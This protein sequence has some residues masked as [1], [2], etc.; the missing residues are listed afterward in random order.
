MYSGGLQ[1]RPSSSDMAPASSVLFTH[2]RDG[3]EPSLMACFSWSC[4]KKRHF[5][6]LS[7][8]A[9]VVY[10]GF[11]TPEEEAKPGIMATRLDNTA[12][13][14]SVFQVLCV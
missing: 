8:H 1:G 13:S 7:L 3:G 5:H 12:G 6:N 9:G 2:M 10:I 14:E 4:R 11:K